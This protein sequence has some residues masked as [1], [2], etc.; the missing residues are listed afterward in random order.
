[1][2]LF[3]L[4]SIDLTAIDD[5]VFLVCLGFGPLS[6]ESGQ[7]PKAL[8]NTPFCQISNFFFPSPY[9]VSSYELCFIGSLQSDPASCPNWSDQL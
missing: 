6:Q 8:T 9:S 3:Y 5:T 1:M 4:L 2:F 7:R